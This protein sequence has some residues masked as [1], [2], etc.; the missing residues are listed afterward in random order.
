MGCFAYA[1]DIVLLAPTKYALSEMYK[2]A[3]KFASEYSML[4]NAKKSKLMLFD[5]YKT[6]SMTINDEEF[7]CT[8]QVVHLGNVIGA[9]KNV[10]KM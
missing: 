6:S 7:M 3:C 10:T 4:F 5:T 8:N 9:C 2:V 1:D